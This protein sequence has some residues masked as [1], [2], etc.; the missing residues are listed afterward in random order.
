VIGS[1]PSVAEIFFTYKQ[2]NDSVQKTADY[3]DLPFKIVQEAINYYSE[4]SDEI[5]SEIEDGF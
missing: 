4:F 2:N 1:R 5:N 3:L